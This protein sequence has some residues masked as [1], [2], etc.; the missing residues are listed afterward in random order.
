M[1]T[2]SHSD[3]VID[4]PKACIPEFFDELDAAKRQ[5]LVIGSGAD[6]SKVLKVA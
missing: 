1:E 4:H 6:A 5:A 3:S 2:N